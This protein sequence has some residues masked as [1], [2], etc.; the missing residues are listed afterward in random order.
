MGIGNSAAMNYAG[1]VWASGFPKGSWYDESTSTNYGAAGKYVIYKWDSGTNDWELHGIPVG[2]TNPMAYDGSTSPRNCGVSLS[3]NDAGDVF[4]VGCTGDHPTGS[5]YVFEYNAGSDTWSMKGDKITL[6]SSARGVGADVKLNGAG[7]VIVVGASGTGYGGEA[8]VLH[9]D[10]STSQWIDD[11]GTLNH[12][13]ECIAWGFESSDRT[14]TPGNVG[15]L[16]K[17]VDISDDGNVAVVA[18]PSG[19]A[20]RDN[21]SDFSIFSPGYV[22]VLQWDATHSEWQT[23]DIELSGEEENY[24]NVQY[25]GQNVALSSDGTLLAVSAHNAFVEGTTCGN[26]Q[27]DPWVQSGHNAPCG[28]QTGK[29]Y[30]YEYDG[31]MW[32]R[33]DVINGI[34]DHAWFGVGI[35]LSKDGSRLAA[36]GHAEIMDQT[37]HFKSSRGQRFWAYELSGRLQPSNI[38]STQPAGGDPDTVDL[39]HAHDWAGSSSMTAH[40]NQRFSGYPTGFIAPTSSECKSTEFHDLRLANLGVHLDPDTYEWPAYGSL[41]WNDGSGSA[42]DGMRNQAHGRRLREA[43]AAD[44]DAER[45]LLGGFANSTDAVGGDPL[46]DAVVTAV[47]RMLTTS[48]EQAASLFLRLEPL[49]D[50]ALGDPPP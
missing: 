42:T 32:T 15:G 6:Y 4:A 36:T 47:D 12:G 1:D 20:R 2:G 5:V 35:G 44:D 48:P 9:W 33:S 49:L 14:C 31:W 8:R 18:K 22:R 11:G 17:A 25:F 27:P 41:Q 34:L 38:P 28:A 50:K 30:I 19:V 37:W 3:L 40:F 16:G 24:G 10:T 21:E 29:V 45:L 26:G 43:G 39:D 7:D 13:S 23:Q 46:E